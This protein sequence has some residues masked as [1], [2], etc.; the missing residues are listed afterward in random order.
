MST[1]Q[2]TV[3]YTY[4][5]QNELKFSQV[6]FTVVK[7]TRGTTTE[8]VY[9]IQSSVC[10]MLFNSPS[11]FLSPNSRSG[12]VRISIITVYCA[13]TSDRVGGIRCTFPLGFLKPGFIQTSCITCKVMHGLLTPNRKTISSPLYL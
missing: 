13:V 9:E 7:Q 3:C 12:Q 8:Q 4:C 1:K 11:L 2:D 10:S 5:C 6:T